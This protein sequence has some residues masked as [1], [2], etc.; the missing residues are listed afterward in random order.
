MTDGREKR[1]ANDT[2]M[3]VMGRT[4]ERLYGP[5]AVDDFVASRLRKTEKVWRERAA[6]CGRGDPG[7]LLCLFSPDAHEYE[8]IRNDDECLEVNVT[9]C[10]H[11]EL[12]RSYGAADLGAKLICGGD[13]AVVAGYNPDLKLERPTTCMTGDCCHFVF[14]MRKK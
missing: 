10:V 9:K 7:Y 4:M 2:L 1:I 13:H 8:V 3:V 6:E 12:F 14:R 5:D 11:A